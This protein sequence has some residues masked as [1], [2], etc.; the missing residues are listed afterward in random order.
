MDVNEREALEALVQDE[1]WRLFRRHVLAEWGPGGRQF[2]DATTKAADTKADADA[3]AFLRQIIVAQ[4]E[5]QRV[6]QWPE[7]QV[8]RLKES[9]L[10][11]VGV[12]LSRR[13]AL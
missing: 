13:G 11:P 6:V 2:I 5:I 8:K 1:G 4:R 10:Q 9:E 7:E 3:V 12:A